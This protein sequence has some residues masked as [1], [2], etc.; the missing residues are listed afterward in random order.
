MNETSPW[1]LALAALPAVAALIK[2]IWPSERRGV[3][4]RLTR[5]LEMY[6]KTPESAGRKALEVAGHLAQQLAYLE[7]RRLRRKVDGANIAAIVFVVVV[8]GGIGFGLWQLDNIV[9]QI[10]AILVIAFT[11]VLVVVGGVPQIMKTMERYPFQEPEKE[12][13]P[14]QRR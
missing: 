10:V 14:R 11:T 12:R 1:S 4:H 9:M 3:G 2:V 13:R 8:G 7:D 6:E 5:V